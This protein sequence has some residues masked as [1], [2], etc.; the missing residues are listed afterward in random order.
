MPRQDDKSVQNHATLIRAVHP[1]WLQEEGG[2]ERLTSQT[3]KDG[4]LEASCFIAE[5]VGGLEGFTQD[6]LPILA[7]E[8]GFRPEHVALLTAIEA[9]NAD[10]WIYRKPEEFHDNPAH[11]VICPP[12]G[13]SKS[14]YGKQSG[15]LAS[16]AKAA[17]VPKASRHTSPG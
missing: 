11:V 16:R 3:F 13:M 15:S 7:K 6:I 8:L 1:D 10:L 12:D 17:Q 5:E 2:V 14:K 9:R 4:S